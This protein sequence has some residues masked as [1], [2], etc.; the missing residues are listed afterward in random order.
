MLSRIQACVRSWPAAPR[1]WSAANGVTLSGVF[2]SVLPTVDRE[3]LSDRTINAHAN[4]VVRDHGGDK[5][6]AV[7]DAFWPA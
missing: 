5:L 2:H 7:I 1:R 4:S 6:L 3:K